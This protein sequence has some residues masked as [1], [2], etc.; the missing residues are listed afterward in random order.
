MGNEL[1]DLILTERD[2][3]ILNEINRWRYCQG[4]HVK[5]ICGFSGQ[6][7]TDRRL[8][9]LMKEGLLERERPL[10][11][12]AGV[13]TLTHKGKKLIGVNKRPE[14][15]RID[16][17]PHDIA[18]LDTVCLFIEKGITSSENIKSEKELYSIDGFGNREHHP[19][20]IFSKC[21]KDSNKNIAV[22]IELTA[23]EKTRFE[24]N[25]K[26]NYL[27]Y[28]RQIW[29]VPKEQHRINKLLQEFKK[30]YDTIEIVFLELISNGE[31]QQ[32]K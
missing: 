25:V 2:Y 24:K 9:I 28:D 23:K 14:K 31:F 5:I 18:V 30:T 6:R 19:D 3:L 15:I 13:Y 4:K 7:A 22:E 12:F 27:N 17:I 21:E 29:I 26:S 8:S 16:R 10:F 1:I 20:F 32:F 11:S